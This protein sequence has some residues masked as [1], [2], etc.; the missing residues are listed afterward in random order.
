MQQPSRLA[1]PACCGFHTPDLP[2]SPAVLAGAEGAAGGWRFPIDSLTLLDV[3]V[4]GGKPLKMEQLLT[5]APWTQQPERLAAAAKAAAA[6][7]ADACKRP[8]YDAL[9]HVLS[10]LRQ[11]GAVP[12]GVLGAD[13][14]LQQVGGPAVQH[15]AAAQGKPAAAPGGKGAPRMARFVGFMVKAAAVVVGTEP[16]LLPDRLMGWVTQVSSSPQYLLGPAA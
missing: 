6:A 1:V 10:S 16:P 12:G 2:V 8:S 9:T 11:P 7:G 14:T 15:D 5:Q 4:D 3:V 13:R